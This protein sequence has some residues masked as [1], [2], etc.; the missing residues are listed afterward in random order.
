MRHLRGRQQIERVPSIKAILLNHD[1]FDN[2]NESQKTAFF[3]SCA[4]PAIVGYYLT[5]LALVKIIR[6]RTLNRVMP[7]TIDVGT[8]RFAEGLVINQNFV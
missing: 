4:L 3:V 6:M 7:P 2:M 8:G 1:Q 5:I